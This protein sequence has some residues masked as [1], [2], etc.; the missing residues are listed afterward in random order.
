MTPL[1]LFLLETVLTPGMPLALH[2]FEMRYRQMIGLCIATKQPFGVVLIRPNVQPYPVGCSARV[3]QSERLE[4]GR[5]NII[6]IGQERFRILSYQH[7]QPYPVGLVEDYPARI[8]D[9]EQAQRLGEMLRP[10]VQSYLRILSRVNRLKL[11]RHVLPQA[12]LA[13]AYTAI[14]VVQTSAPEK[15]AILA[16]ETVEGMLR[17]LHQLYRREVTIAHASFKRPPPQTIGGFSIN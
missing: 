15:Q 8:E 3:I 14:H 16:A 9:Q 12:P 4:D 6:A 1:P 5:M 7:D 2:V 10:W 11:Q 13:L 17:A